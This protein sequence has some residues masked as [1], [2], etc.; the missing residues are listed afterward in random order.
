MGGAEPARMGGVEPAGMD[1]VDS[2]GRVAGARSGST[3]GDPAEYPGAAIR[4]GSRYGS[5]GRSETASTERRFN[6]MVRVATGGELDVPV[7]A[8]DS[9]LR[10]AALKHNKSAVA[11]S[12]GRRSGTRASFWSKLSG[13]FIFKQYLPLPGQQYNDYNTDGENYVYSDYVPAV[14]LRAGINKRSY[15]QGSFGFHSPQYSKS[16]FITQESYLNA[17]TLSPYNGYLAH[18]VITLKKLFYNELDL[19]YHYRIADRWWLGAGVQYAFL[20]GGVATS[21]TTLRPPASTSGDTVV[22]SEILSIKH[23]T[24]LYEWVQDKTEW[25]GVVDIDYAWD[26]WSIGMRYQQAVRNFSFSVAGSD[27]TMNCSLNIQASYALWRAKRR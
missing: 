26:R 6:S 10:V 13:G 27:A 4:V 21:Q 5:A 25:R 15:L 7:R 20:G 8:A 23:Q 24:S 22:T 9:L 16:M 3:G 11:A 18:D 12:T 1:G 2:A 19:V 17:N 14:F